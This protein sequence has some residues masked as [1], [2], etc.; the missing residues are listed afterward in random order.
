MVQTKTPVWKALGNN[1]GHL[2]GA[3]DRC[4]FRVKGCGP[5]SCSRRSPNN[6]SFRVRS[7]TGASLPKRCK[8]HYKPRRVPRNFRAS[9][10][11]IVGTKIQIA[12]ALPEDAAWKTMPAGEKYA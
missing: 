9:A 7:F 11:D 2:L 3:T 1:L 8:R 10:M 6:V 5:K 12:L 4:L